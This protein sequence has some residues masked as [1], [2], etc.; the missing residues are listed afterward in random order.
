MSQSLNY[1]Y[2]L[3]KLLDKK[4]YE[5]VLRILSSKLNAKTAFLLNYYE[6]QNSADILVGYNIKNEFNEYLKNLN[7]KKLFNLKKE[8][9]KGL[10]VVIN[11]IEEIDNF[12]EFKNILSDRNKKSAVLLPIR[13]NEKEIIGIL[14]LVD[15]AKNKWKNEDIKILEIL[16]YSLKYNWEDEIL[17]LKYKSI[18]QNSASAIVIIDIN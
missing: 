18:I 8:L 5:E 10:P 15:K 1:I 4:E 11:D 16:T 13:D 9:S 2:K 7:I 6:Y 12:L 17:R 14:G 3:V